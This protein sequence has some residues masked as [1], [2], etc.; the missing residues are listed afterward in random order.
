MR[1]IT[2][3]AKH[4]ADCPDLGSILAPGSLARGVGS[5]QN[6]PAHKPYE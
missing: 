1:E 4:G 5:R 3:M 6:N 2:E